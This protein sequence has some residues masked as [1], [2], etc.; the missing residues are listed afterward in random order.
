VVNNY[1]IKLIE[2][3]VGNYALTGVLIGFFSP[4]ALAFNPNNKGD[5]GLAAIPIVTTII[6]WI[7]GANITDYEPVY[8]YVSP[9]EYDFKQLKIYARHVNNEPEFLK[10]IK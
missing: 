6:G 1:D 5:I 10:N 9:E 7:I 8:E 2:L 4:L 3:K